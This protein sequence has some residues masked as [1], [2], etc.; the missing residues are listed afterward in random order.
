MIKWLLS[1]FGMLKSDDKVL[2]DSNA[3]E[4]ENDPYLINLG[5][6]VDRNKLGQSGEDYFRALFGQCNMTVEFLGDK[7]PDVDCFVQFKDKSRVYEFLVQV[8]STGSLGENKTTVYSGLSRDQYSRLKA[9]H[10]PTYLARVDMHSYRVFIKGAFL[11]C[12]KANYTTVS[13]KYILSIND[14]EG[15]RNIVKGI[16]T[17]VKRYWDNGIDPKYKDNYK[18]YFSNGKK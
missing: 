6:K 2:P 8:K 5:V 15:S 4:W 7:A 3:Y 1:L 14:L 13:K 9:Y 16:A 11:P 10:V 17:D 18:S 12:V